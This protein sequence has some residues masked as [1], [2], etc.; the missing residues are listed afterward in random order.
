MDKI[1]FLRYHFCT[2]KKIIYIIRNKEMMKVCA[3]VLKA[4]L[5]DKKIFFIKAA[6]KKTCENVGRSNVGTSGLVLCLKKWQG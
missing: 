3:G 2:D 4:T 6:E 5:L 1:L